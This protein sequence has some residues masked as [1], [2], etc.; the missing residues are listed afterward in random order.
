MKG[1]SAANVIPAFADGKVKTV[2]FEAPAFE[3]I[4]D[5]EVESEVYGDGTTVRVLLRRQLNFRPSRFAR[6]PFWLDLTV[7][8]KHE[9]YWNVPEETAREA[10]CRFLLRHADG[11]AP[12]IN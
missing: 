6:G 10:A 7:G 4:E 11:V 8:S 1:K 3:T 2:A 9:S 5:F 12:A